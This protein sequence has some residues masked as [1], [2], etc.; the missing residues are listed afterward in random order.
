MELNLIGHFASHCGLFIYYDL[1][2]FGLV[3]YLYL[4][5]ANKI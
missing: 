4:V 3:F 2:L 5:T 1:S